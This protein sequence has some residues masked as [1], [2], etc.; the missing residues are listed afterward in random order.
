D[1]ADVGEEFQI[2]LKQTDLACTCHLHGALGTLDHAAR[3]VRLALALASE[4]AKARLEDVLDP[5]VASTAVADLA[6]Q[7]GQIATGP[8][9][10]LERLGIFQRRLGLRVLADDDHPRQ[11][12]AH[13]QHGQHELYRQ[14]RIRD[15]RENVQSTVHCLQVL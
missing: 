13:E 6:E 7:L 11:E 12:R 1:R 2:A 9:T 14:A 5:A 15:Q 3:I 10:L 8:E 4:L